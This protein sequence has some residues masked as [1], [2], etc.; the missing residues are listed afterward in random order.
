VIPAPVPVQSTRLQP[1]A[2]KGDDGSNTRPPVP[3]GVAEYFLPN[4]LTLSRALQATGRPY[5]KEAF[6]QGLLYRPLLIAQASIRFFNRKYGLDFENH[7]T[8]L[9]PNPDRRGALRWESYL[10][11]AVDVR[12]LDEQPAPGARFATLE[13]PLN[14]AKVLALL[15][16]DFVDWVY[17]NGTIA[18]RANETLK[19]YAGPEVSS[20]DFRSM[21]SEAARAGFEAESRKAA[22]AFDRKLDTLVAR[23]ER[24]ERALAKNETELSERKMEEWGTHAENVF[25]FLTGKRSTRRISSSLTKRR[26]TAQAKA[27]VEEGEETLVDLKKEIAALEKEKDA[28]IEEIRQRW[29]ELVNRAGELSVA[30]RKTDILVDAFGVAWMPYHVVRIAAAGGEET[31][32]LPGYAPGE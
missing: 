22:G 30:P 5:P 25:S 9:A 24:I 1:A 21:C 13:A 31:L 11:A 20:A 10:S 18:V 14:D 15:Q 7:K 4:N 2:P 12:G 29:G 26:L 32:E 3:T 6:S 23:A 8:A 17:R 19:V 16:R 27:D 28:A